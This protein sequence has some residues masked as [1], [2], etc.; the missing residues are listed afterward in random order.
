MWK[1]FD[2]A[3]SANPE[4]GIEVG[5]ETPFSQ[6]LRQVLH[7]GDFNGDGRADMIWYRPPD[8]T[9]DETLLGKT[10]QASGGAG[11]WL[12]KSCT[13]VWGKRT[14]A[15]ESTGHNVN[16]TT[17]V[18]CC[19]KK[20]NGYPVCAQEQLCCLKV[21]EGGLKY[22]YV[23]HI[24]RW[25]MYG[26]WAVP[27]QMGDLNGDNKTDVVLFPSYEATEMF[28]I[29]SEALLG[30]WSVQRVDTPVDSSQTS[31][32]CIAGMVRLADVC[33]IMHVS[34]ILLGA[35]YILTT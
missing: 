14:C 26:S 11:V 12:T 4:D 8:V 21:K 17:P 33:L 10:K 28:I 20:C 29:W 22:Y 5:T 25:L 9:T 7:F 13:G 27:L 32:R 2:F 30:D 23:P 31:T 16:R 24:L 35:L 19:S 34:M 1:L 3:G 6:R 18:K 15:V